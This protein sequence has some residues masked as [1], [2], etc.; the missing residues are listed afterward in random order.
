MDD[1]DNFRE[2]VE[3]KN[4]YSILLEI[5]KDELYEEDLVLSLILIDTSSPEDVLIGDEL[6]KKEVAVAAKN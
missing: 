4:F 2:M 1:C 6:I 5:E 3:S